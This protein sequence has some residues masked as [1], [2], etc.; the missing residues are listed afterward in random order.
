MDSTV[1]KQASDS[2]LVLATE[3]QLYAFDLSNRFRVAIGRHELN[4]LQLESRTVSNFHAEILYENGR[5]TLR[6]LGSTNGTFVNDEGIREQRVASGDRIR[7]GSHVMTVQRQAP[8]SKYERLLR[9][10]R[11]PDAFGPGTTGRIVSI[12]T[13]SNDTHKTLRVGDPNDLPL[14]DLLK[15]LTGNTHSILLT[16]THKDEQ[17]HV[18]V[19]NGRIVHAEYG[20]VTGT[21]ALYRLFTW[22]NASYKVDDLSEEH[23]T[24]RSIELPV[25]CL[26][27][28]G[29]KHASEI[30]KLLGM[31][32]P[33]YAL[34]QLK[35]DCTLSMSAYT[36]AEL[37][38]F[39]AV[40]RHET[41]A[42]VLETSPMTDTTVLRLIEALVRKGVFHVARKA[43]GRLVDT[44]PLP[45]VRRPL[46]GALDA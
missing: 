5:L 40:I 13:A 37:Q 34:L 33:L 25:D 20:S 4:E 16:L 39:Q 22:P 3:S 19:R 8:V 7:I 30:A 35:E 29:I 18:W 10:P 44:K 45:K 42:R 15:I 46:R 36:P 23:S 17:A 12:P 24:P 28:E 9:V 14:V 27:V 32:P 38:I 11:D 41:T 26:I 43:D 6:D 21:K 2:L 31:L 1:E